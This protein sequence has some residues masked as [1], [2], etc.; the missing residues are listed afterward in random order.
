MELNHLTAVPKPQK[1]P[2]PHPEKKMEKK[3]LESSEVTD[4]GLLWMSS[5][6]GN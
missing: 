6:V 3:K 1:I 5:T 4:S 2:Q